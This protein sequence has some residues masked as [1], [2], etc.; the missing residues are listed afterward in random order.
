MSVSTEIFSIFFFKLILQISWIRMDFW[1][2]KRMRGEFLVHLRS[3]KDLIFWLGLI[4]ID[5]GIKRLE[6]NWQIHFT[7]E[8][9]LQLMRFLFFIWSCLKLKSIG[10]WVRAFLIFRLGWASGHGKRDTCPVPLPRVPRFWERGGTGHGLK[11][12]RSAP[13][14]I[15]CSE[16][17]FFDRKPVLELLFW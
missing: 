12:P 3:T 8:S 17:R 13:F 4:L 6:K 14:F 10:R 9:L 16:T 2:K 5:T 7:R 11:V 15:F 1:W